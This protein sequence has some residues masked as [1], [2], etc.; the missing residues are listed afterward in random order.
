MRFIVTA[1]K[2]AGDWGAIYIAKKIKEFQ[3]AIKEAKNGINTTDERRRG[4]RSN[5][6]RNS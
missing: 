3:R 6:E 1:N 5:E 4:Y 2:R